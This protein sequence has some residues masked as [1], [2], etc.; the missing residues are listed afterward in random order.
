[1]QPAFDPNPTKPAVKNIMGHSVKELQKML[2]RKLTF[3]EK[4]VWNAAK[5]RAKY[6]NWKEGEPTPRQLKQGNIAVTLGGIGIGILF[7]AMVGVNIGAFAL[8][9]IPLGI[10]AL[11][12]G[13]KSSKGNGNTMGILG[14]V[15]GAAITF[16]WL[17]AVVALAIFFSSWGSGW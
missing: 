10:G 1:M 4:I 8:L 6:F 14:I 12:F 17:L 3:R 11:I 13:I 5:I 16:I 7:L 15:S 9:S 2:G